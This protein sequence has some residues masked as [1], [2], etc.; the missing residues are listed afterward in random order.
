LSFSVGGIGHR[1]HSNQDEAT[2][3]RDPQPLVRSNMRKR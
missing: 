1:Q 3:Y 2:F